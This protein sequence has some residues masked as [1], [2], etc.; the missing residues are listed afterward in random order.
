MKRKIQSLFC[1]AFALMLGACSTTTP[2]Q[3]S[4][5]TTTSVISSEVSIDSTALK[6]DFYEAVN[7]QW[8]EAAVIPSDQPSIGGF[9][10]LSDDADDA[11]MADF[12]EMLDGTKEPTNDEL[13]N[14]IEYYR[15]ATDF[16]AREALGTAP[17][18][19]YFD[20]IEKLSS[21]ADYS[22]QGSDFVLGT[23]PN[24]FGLTVMA[25]MGNADI[26]ALYAGA[27]TL[28]LGDKSYYEDEA[29]K[30][31][32]QALY[33]SM[34]IE[35]LTL[36]GRTEEEAQKVV[37]NALSFD[38]SLVPYIK[39]SV[40]SSDVAAMYN[41]TDFSEFAGSIQN[42]DFTTTV[43]TLVGKT[44]ETIIVADPN[45][46][47]NFDQIVNDASFE[48]MKDWMTVTTVISYSSY[49]TEEMRIAGSS[50]S[51]A[52]A[53]VTENTPKE[54]T[55]YYVADNFFTEVVG[56]YY[57]K[58]Y[59]GEEAKTAANEMVDEIIAVYKERLE[60]NT[61]LSEDTKTMAVKK[62]DAMTINVGYP[63]EANELYSKFKTVS[64]SEG[65]TLISNA[66]AFTLLV[67]QDQFSKVGEAVD[68][69]EWPLSADTVNAMY[70]PLD[71]SIN[72]PAA[73]LQAPFFDV[74]QSKEANYGG[75]GA[76]IGHEISHAF[77]PNGSLF[78]EKGSL[79]NWWTEEDYAKFNELSQ[80]MVDEFNGI[81]VDGGTV[82]GE[83]TLT[84]N[85]ADAGGLSCALEAIK[86]DPDAD[87]SEFFESWATIW[88]QKATP[89]YEAMLLAVDVH[90]PNKLRTN[91]QLE[92]LDDFY[93]TYDIVEGDGMYRAP[94][95]RVSIW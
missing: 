7:A 16:E 85:V 5:A 69:G 33:F 38:E 62:L 54:E 46:F 44:P 60:N 36:S 80:A 23:M 3:A 67:Q 32:C 90:A 68:R 11:L 87:L 24:P 45:F 57:G 58:T 73:I 94:E 47:N 50:Y 40:E 93:T 8:L 78:D 12:Q 6:S 48:Q 34:A 25:D 22:A 74:N 10:V 71:N 30:A 14:F 70:S 82:N 2:D 37:E 31:Q 42:F 72:F 4:S 35:L 15:L 64:A 63:E 17:L 83:L 89:E 20:K 52:L 66:D 41:P 75:I 61:W 27:P 21:L 9:S 86:K 56:I 95:D 53:G 84:E 55:A 18:V 77:D 79:N 81:E 19:P 43:N 51:L 49:L 1:L 91:I 76:V 29:T 92:N 39:S 28:L 88:R 59:F 65:G 13:K 26:N